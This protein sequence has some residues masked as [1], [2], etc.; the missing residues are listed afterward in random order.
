MGPREGSRGR[1][2]D[3]ARPGIADMLQWGRVK[4][5]AEGESDSATHRPLTMLQWGRVK[6][7]AEGFLAFRC[8][9]CPRGLLQWGRVKDH[10]EGRGYVITRAALDKASMGPREGSRGRSVGVCGRERSRHAS[11]GPREG[12]RGRRGNEDHPSFNLGSFNGAA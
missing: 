12:S 6:D 7:H 9:G 1:E 2:E 8:R 5:H 11:M 10:A 4:D 3:A